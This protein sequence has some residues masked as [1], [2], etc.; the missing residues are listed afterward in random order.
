MVTMHRLKIVNTAWL[1]ALDEG[2]LNTPGHPRCHENPT[3]Y[4]IRKQCAVYILGWPTALALT[5]GDL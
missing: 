2:M 3:T 4:S 1:D 5:A